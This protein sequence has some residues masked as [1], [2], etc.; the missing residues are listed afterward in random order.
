MTRLKS[1]S[2]H[3]FWRLESIGAPDSSESLK[4]PSSQNKTKRLFKNEKLSLLTM[5]VYVYAMR[6]F[7]REQNVV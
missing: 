3:N 7:H 4:D 6:Y 5:Q 2:R 1:D